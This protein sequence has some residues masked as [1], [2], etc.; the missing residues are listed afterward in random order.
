[1]QP[2]SP[3]DPPKFSAVSDSLS[4][5]TRSELSNN[6]CLKGS[7]SLEKPSRAYSPRLARSFSAHHQPPH[8]HY[9]GNCQPCKGSSRFQVSQTVTS[10]AAKIEG[11]TFTRSKEGKSSGVV[12]AADANSG[13]TYVYKIASP[14]EV[15]ANKVFKAVELN[16]P[17]FS[18]FKAEELFDGLHQKLQ[19]IHKDTKN[20]AKS[21]NSS[22]PIM[23]MEF[24]K[25]SDLKGKSADDLIKILSKSDNLHQLGQSM[26]LDALMGN[27]DRTVFATLVK[28]NPCNIMT[29]E[30]KLMFIDQG[31]EPKNPKFVEKG[32][33]S[34]I[35]AVKS[36]ANDQNSLVEKYIY[37]LIE[38][39]LS[40]SSAAEVQNVISNIGHQNI[41]I[42]L[43]KGIIEGYDKFLTCEKQL[44]AE[45]KKNDL[46]LEVQSLFKLAQQVK[47]DISQL[48]SKYFL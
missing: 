15:F 28:T 11:F 42:T 13:E 35:S 30:G 14:R 4:N 34:L 36:H 46:N 20:L 40:S 33:M 12:F 48:K 24:I 39:I 25:G 10:S 3:N 7:G 26:I 41:Q 6:W 37:K 8:I 47:S 17:K 5:L 38:N 43:S 23:Q 9:L 21:I 27:Y 2:I 32:L 45:A 19:E 1:M 18:T 44:V 31:F 16:I 22:F 29:V